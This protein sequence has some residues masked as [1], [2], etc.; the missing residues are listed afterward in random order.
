M[1]DDEGK[2]RSRG[3]F[4]NRDRAIIAIVF[5]IGVIA[6]IAIANQF[7]DPALGS[8]M[9]VQYGALSEKNKALD[10]QADS[11]YTCL[12]KLKIDPATCEKAK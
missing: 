8:G 1:G 4:W 3:S 9:V 12:Q 5:V 2:K 11:Y 10:D 7:I 6:G